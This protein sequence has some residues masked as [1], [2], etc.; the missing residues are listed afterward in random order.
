MTRNEVERLAAYNAQ[1]SYGIK[2]TGE[3]KAAMSKLQ[4]LFDQK[5]ASD[6]KSKGW[7]IL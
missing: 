4:A 1:V 2:H 7:L 5:R 3:I 6:A